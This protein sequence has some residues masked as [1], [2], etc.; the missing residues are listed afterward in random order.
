[1]KWSKDGVVLFDDLRYETS[2]DVANGVHTLRV[3]TFHN[4]MYLSL[5]PLRFLR[6]VDKTRELI[7]VWLRMRADPPLQRASLLSMVSK[8]LSPF[9]LPSSDASLRG[10]SKSDSTPPKIAIKLSD[11]R[12]TEGQPL[13]MECKVSQCSLLFDY[14]SVSDRWVPSSFS[15]LAQGWSSASALRSTSGLL[16][17]RISPCAVTLGVDREEWRRE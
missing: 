3:R 7:V 14:M 5:F 1:M 8:R 11:V 17:N 13:K 16:Y 9:H 6:L 15:H 12:T 4:T 2:S 10:P